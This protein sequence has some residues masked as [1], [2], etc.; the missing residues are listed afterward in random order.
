M[1]DAE[2]EV[3]QT[4]YDEPETLT[5]VLTR[6]PIAFISAL[7][8]AISSPTAKPKRAVLRTHLL[9]LVTH[10]WPATPETT[11]LEIFHRILFPLLLFTKARQKSTEAVWTILGDILGSVEW[12]R[13]CSTIKLANVSD[14]TEGLV[15]IN[16]ELAGKIAG[17]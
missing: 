1:Q 5:S 16:S 13:D 8:L 14:S 15:S 17:V 6:E 4:L 9:Y 11:Q 10:F 12:L 7:E 3:L 2:V